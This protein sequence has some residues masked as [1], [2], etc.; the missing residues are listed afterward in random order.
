MAHRD[1]EKYLEERVKEL[2]GAIDE[3]GAAL[4]SKAQERVASIVESL[5]WEARQV[6]GH[7]AREQRRQ[8][9][10]A[11]RLHFDNPKNSGIVAEVPLERRWKYL[12]F[13]DYERERVRMR[14]N[15]LG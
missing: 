11:G 7:V 13:E 14:P 15:T 6:V 5:N 12:T 9:F 8:A 10:E 3:L 4:T 2:L 1:Y